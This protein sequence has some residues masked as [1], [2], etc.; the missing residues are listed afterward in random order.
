MKKLLPILL[1]PALLLGAEKF[2]YPYP[3][4]IYNEG[5]IWKGVDHLANLGNSIPLQVDILAPQDLK[6]TITESSVNEVLEKVFKDAGFNNSPSPKGEH[7][8]FSMMIL[9]FPINEG[10]AASIQGRLFEEVQV[11]RTLIAK[12]HKLQAET[13]DQSTLIV[14]PT[15][16]FD[17]LLYKS[18]SEVATNFVKRVQAFQGKRP[19]L[20]TNEETK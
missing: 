4:D 9:I 5:G 12:D 16:E 14:A 3:G 20:Q 1:A 13:W 11:K 2:Y 7:A 15:A 10:L 8:F 6:L 17:E 19:S 18:V